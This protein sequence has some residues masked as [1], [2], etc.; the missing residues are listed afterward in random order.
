M[1]SRT[2]TDH[3]EIRRWAE[4]QGGRPAAV[5]ARSDVEA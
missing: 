1:S 5:D 3:D 4:E 2:T